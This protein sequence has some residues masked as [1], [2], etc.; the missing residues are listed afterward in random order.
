[1]R[2]HG[3]CVLELSLLAGILAFP[4]TPAAAGAD[5]EPLKAG[6]R[7]RYSTSPNREELKDAILVEVTDKTLTVNPRKGPAK[8]RVVPLVAVTKLE[9]VRGRRPLIFEGALI[10]A[11]AGALLGWASGGSEES[12]SW[13]MSY[14]FLYGTIGGTLAGA[15]TTV[16]RWKEVSK[17]EIRL[18]ARPLPRGFGAQLALRF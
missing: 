11:A 15:M 17:R 2:S 13:K 3:R 9:V 4:V 7:I 16:D 12:R 1:M 5:S 14:G 8:L 18:S 6:E 10:G